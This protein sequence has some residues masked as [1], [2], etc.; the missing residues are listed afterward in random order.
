MNRTL[1]A[2]GPDGGVICVY[3]GWGSEDLTP[4]E[5]VDSLYRSCR[6]LSAYDAVWPAVGLDWGYL[7]LGLRITGDGCSV[8]PT[9]YTLVERR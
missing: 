8:E 6:S 9:G 3:N 5:M 4:L 1:Q 7:I 2:V